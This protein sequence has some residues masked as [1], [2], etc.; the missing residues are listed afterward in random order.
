MRS[1]RAVAIAFV[2]GL[3]CTHALT[4][5]AQAIPPAAADTSKP[6]E[7]RVDALVDA[8]TLEEKVSQMIDRAPAI[9]RLGIPEY[10]WWNEG[11]HGVGRSGNATMFPQ[12]IG[13][14]ATWDAPLLHEEASVISDEARAK[15]NHALGEGNH[16]RYFGLTFYSPNINIFRDPRWGRGQETYGEDPFLTATLGVA[17]VKG[18][19]GDNPRYYETVATS[20]HLAVHS[21]PESTRHKV[22]VLPTAHDVEDTYLPAF[23]ATLVDGHAASLMCAYNS[24]NGDPACSNP[25]LLRDTVREAWGFQGYIT[26]DCGAIDDLYNGHHKYPDAEH[27]AAAAVLAGTD[28]ECGKSFLA[29]TKAVKSG[30]IPESAVDSSVKRLFKARM[31]LG[32]FDPSENVPFNAIPFSDV[33]S[34][35]HKQLSLQASKESMV[36]LKNDG[37]LPLRSTTRT[38]AVIGPNAQSLAALEGNYNAIPLEPVLPIDGIEHG[39]PGARVLFAQGSPYTSELFVPAPRTLFGSGLKGEY[40]NNESLSGKATVVRVDRQIDFDWAHAS[41][42]PH[43][44]STAFSVR[45]T[46]TITVPKAGVYEFG[47]QI[48]RCSECLDKT[49]RDK[50]AVFLDDKAVDTSQSVTS[51]EGWNTRMPAISLA[52][53]DTKSHKIRIEYRHQSIDMPSQA[54]L[55]WKP[56]VEIERQEAV[57]T[58]QKADVVVAVVG[59]SPELEGE[60]MP[61]HV[62]GFS[63]GDRTSLDLPEVELQLLHALKQTGKP[64]VIVAMNGS[65]LALNW[66]QENANA[67]LEAWYPGE[68]GGTAIADTLAGRNNPGGKLPLTFYTGVDQLPAFDD[69][70]MSRRTYRYFDGKPLY[71]FGYGLSYTHFTFSDLKLSTDQL[72]AGQ[73]LEVSAMLRNAGKQDGDEVAE[74]Y[75][76]PPNMPGS[77]KLALRAFSRLHL[78]PGESKQV[79]WTLDPRQLSFVDETGKRAVAAGNY[80]LF[81]GGGQ[82]GTDVTTSDGVTGKFSIVGTTELPR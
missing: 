16:Q 41:P 40:F 2:L 75:L 73:P 50:I 4:S 76:M 53:A 8:M 49:E 24:I 72:P 13:M 54:S 17:F 82:P 51:S 35:R 68:E 65:A 34:P 62:P 9:P 27:A 52:F 57:D 32:M 14:A 45:W 64:L 71:G 1:Q 30:L 28:A 25:S 70:S 67:I 37:L 23:R 20:K 47:M 3:F 55:R 60:E 77:P 26:S 58:A 38:I 42:A 15:Y 69:Y 78:A 81:L 7:Q 43:V 18:L 19:Q 48:G 36:L 46:G 5:R 39:F 29:L 21:G 63:G 80:T 33:G 59:L 56:Q 10:N 6:I 44:S 31:Q 61:I 74:L 11:L 66:A 22:D 12:A 79:S